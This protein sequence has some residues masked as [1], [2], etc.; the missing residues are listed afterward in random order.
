LLIGLLGPHDW[1]P[2]ACLF[3]LGIGFLGTSVVICRRLVAGVAV[4]LPGLLFLEIAFRYY[5]DAAP[6]WYSNLLIMAATTVL[7]ETRTSKRLVLAGGLIGLATCFA[8]H[9]GAFA[10]MGIA[11]FILWEG[12]SDAKDVREILSRELHFLVPFA[13]IVAACVGY[14]VLA[15]GLKNFL[16]STIL[17]PLNHWG[18][19]ENNSWSAYAILEII[20][21]VSRGNFHIL[22]PLILSV[23]VPGTYVVTIVLYMHQNTSP[24]SETWRRIMLLNIIGLALF[25]SIVTSASL[26]RLGT[27][28]LPAFIVVVW[29][30]DREARSAKVIQFLWIATIIW[31]LKD[32]QYAQKHWTTYVD[33]PYGRIALLTTDLAPYYDWLARNTHPGEYVFEADGE[34]VYFRFGLENPTKLWGLNPCEITS[35]REIT[36]VL[37]DLDRHQVPIIIW[38]SS[39]DKQCAAS[40]D[41]VEPIRN[42]LQNHYRKVETFQDNSVWERI[43]VLN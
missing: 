3:C 16:Y 1:I 27:I 12:Y 24:A 7:V 9:H 42:Y 39:L 40:S 25:G 32:I 8:Q 37:R 2:N 38:N 22:R 13:M 29:I 23:I 35:S 5:L 20:T 33:T 41:H 15:A 21:E 18:H 28:S 17:F 26:W 36:E 6:H 11:V 30:I 31:I 34:D 43:T 4:Y 10:G 19:A 14:L